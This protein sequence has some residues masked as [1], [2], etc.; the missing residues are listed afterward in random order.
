MSELPRAGE[1]CEACEPIIAA[2]EATGKTWAPTPVGGRVHAA[3]HRDLA[4]LREENEELWRMFN[5]IR[6]AAY[7]LE[8]AI[9]ARRALSET[10]K[11]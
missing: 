3:H 5:P 11:P 10:G 9:K 7:E 6:T 8:E 4:R 1:T 2:Y